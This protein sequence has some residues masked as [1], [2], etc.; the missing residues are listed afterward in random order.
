MN[1]D[2]S[3]DPFLHLDAWVKEA[4]EKGITD[5]NAMVL[6]TVGKDFQPS[7]RVVLYKGLLRGGLS[8]YTNY[9]GRKAQELKNNNKASVNFFWASMALQIRI[10][11]EVHKLTREE[12]EAYFRTRPRLSQLGAWASDQSQEVSGIEE[13][14]K[15]LQIIEE[16]FK[17]QEVPCPPNWGGYHLI[18]NYFE[19]WVGR[20]GRLHERY[21][22]EKKNS[23]WR[24]FMRFP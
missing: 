4:K 12:S 15:K 11:G 16:K 13:L 21:C 20:D 5:P 8:F 17:G 2:H 10:E 9:N 19:F 18:P 6:A 3:L 1:F 7:N 23:T 14:Q 22:Y 24:R